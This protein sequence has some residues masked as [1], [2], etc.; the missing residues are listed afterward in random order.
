MTCADEVYISSTSDYINNDVE[1][2]ITD[3]SRNYNVSE[4]NVIQLFSP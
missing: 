3:A 2:E 1:K 4:E